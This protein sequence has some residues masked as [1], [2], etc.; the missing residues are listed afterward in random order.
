VPKLCGE[1]KYELPDEYNFLTVFQPA[2]PWTQK[3]ILE[4][5]TDKPSNIGNYTARIKVSL[6]NY[7]LIMPVEITFKV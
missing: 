2:D 4:L 3:F 1:R 6:S 5:Q 7:P